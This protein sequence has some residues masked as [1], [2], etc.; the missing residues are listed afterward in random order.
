MDDKK[1]KILMVPSDSQGVG[2]FRSIWPAQALS[3]YFS[4][5][6]SV[7]INLGPN[8]DNL[9]YL[10]QFDIIHFHRHLGPYEMME[11]I[12]PELKAA[13]VTLIMDIDD[14]WEPPTTH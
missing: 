13:G 8:V 3:K 11:K 6:F 4:D 10:K 9:N 14:F 5:E 2:H 1:I 7:E 12:F